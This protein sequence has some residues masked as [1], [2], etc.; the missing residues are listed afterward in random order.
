M[1]RLKRSNVQEVDTEIVVMGGGGSGLAAAVAAAEK[2]AK[3]VLME[4]RRKAGGNS[5]RA[6]GIFAAESHIQKEMKIDARR[7]ELIK[8]AMAY[9]HWEINPRIIH[10]FIN[11]SG[12]T[13]RWL[14]EKGVKFDDVPHFIP[15]QVPRVFHLLRGTGAA[16]VRLLVKKCGELGVPLLYGTAA[17][18]ILTN[19]KGDIAG[20]L[21][22]T[23][24]EK[25]RVTAKSVIIAT[26]GYAG[27]KELLKKYYPH[28]TE[29][30]YVVGLPHSG[31][32]LQMATELGA[33][34]EGLGTLLLRGPY[35]RGPL[36]IVTAAMEPD[37]VWV[38][39]TGERFINEATA[40][41]WPETANAL[42][43]QP[44][45]ISYSL[46]DDKIKQKFIK[47]GIVKGYSRFPP[48]A[49]L[50]ELGEKLQSQANKGKIK[51]SNSW[52]EI[53][54]WMGAVPEALK[55]TI[56]EYNSFCHQNHDEMFFKERRFLQPLLT[57]PYY[58]VRCYQGVYNTIGG[59]KINHHMEVLDRHD[60]PIPGLYAAGT[61]TGGWESR[62]YCLVL[63][64]NAFGYA[65]NSGRIAGENASKYLSQR[66]Q[67]KKV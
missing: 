46:F 33:S 9:S 3:V 58:A 20:V 31:D 64:G 27:N 30:L 28:Y 38:N 4:K 32:G 59:I 11:K 42:N 29:D 34:T 61:D 22:A 16:L 15:N 43:Q 23:K 49:R 48:E 14:E 18:R 53:A 54:G 45:K 51:I 56:D 26:G 57:P 12:D 63:S 62:T 67:K 36:E 65:I 41:H 35:F 5:A 24:D 10:A 25:F 8:I 50:T 37:T 60:N 21:A 7:E 47:D 13:I 52:K 6:R 39:K 44:D 17:K 66:R 19:E 55:A 1:N 2:G 40:F